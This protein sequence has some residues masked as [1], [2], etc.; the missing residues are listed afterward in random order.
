LTPGVPEGAEAEGL[1]VGLTTL[2]PAVTPGFGWLPG[3]CT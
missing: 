1:L 3:L 2:K